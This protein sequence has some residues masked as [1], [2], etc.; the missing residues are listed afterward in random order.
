MRLADAGKVHLIVGGILELLS[1]AAAIVPIAAHGKTIGATSVLGFA[2]FF[3]GVC[4][5]VEIGRYIEAQRNE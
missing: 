4:G 2:T 1:L 3:F 5:G